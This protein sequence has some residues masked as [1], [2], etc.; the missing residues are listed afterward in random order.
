MKRLIFLLSLSLSACATADP[1]VVARAV[2]ATLTA[3]I[4]PTP[5]VVVVTA[6]QPSIPT[7]TPEV[8]GTA[9]PSPVASASSPANGATQ[10]PTLSA[11]VPLGKPIFTDD[12][13][14]P[15][16]WNLSEDIAQRTAVENG[17]LAITLKLPDRFTFVYDLKRRARDFYAQVTAAAA[18]CGFRDRSGLIFRVQSEMDYYLFEVDCDGRY[19]LSTVAGG[20]LA[21][22]KDWTKSDAIRSLGGAVNELSVLAVGGSLE[23]FANGESLVEVSDATYAEGGFGLYAGSGVSQT[24]IV[25]FDD[26]RIWEL[27]Q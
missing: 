26:L 2:N 16:L 19:R 10:T 13:T 3:V 23:I 9:V 25:I 20:A 18:A 14:R 22:L 21:P 1:A 15:G 5:I 11:P 17:Q 8:S 7:A 12:F 24:Y 4:T 27:Q 6:L